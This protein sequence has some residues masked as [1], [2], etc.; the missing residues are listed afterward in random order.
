MNF[1]K[2]KSEKLAFFVFKKYNYIIMRI[3]IKKDKFIKN[4]DKYI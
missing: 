3:L 4:I 2:S 1:L